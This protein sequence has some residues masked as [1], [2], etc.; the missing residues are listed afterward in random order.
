MRNVTDVGT[1]DEVSPTRGDVKTALALER[2]LR[3]HR[4][5]VGCRLDDT[6]N[7]I[8]ELGDHYPTGVCG[9][10]DVCVCGFVCGR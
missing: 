10:A 5:T 2:H 4:V 6:S 8:A 3:P 7:V 1:K 9:G